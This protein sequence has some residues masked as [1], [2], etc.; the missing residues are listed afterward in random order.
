MRS[1]RRSALA[2]L[3]LWTAFVAHPCC[4]CGIQTGRH[5]SLLLR[6]HVR[7]AMVS[8]MIHGASHL[9]APQLLRTT[10]RATILTLKRPRHLL[11]D[12]WH[13]VT[14]TRGPRTE[15]QRSQRF[16][17]GAVQSR[18][19]WPGCPQRKQTPAPASGQLLDRWPTLP[20][21]KQAPALPADGAVG[22]AREV[23]PSLPQ[24]KHVVLFFFSCGQ[25]LE[26]CPARP[27]L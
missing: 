25:S 13:T 7:T 19:I 15:P 27:Q 6:N 17:S 1:T 23:C 3:G 14:D 10:T 16:L 5:A 22:H 24:R 20:Q 26:K 2:V 9:D 8:R 21:W 4:P 12:R 18:L 11:A